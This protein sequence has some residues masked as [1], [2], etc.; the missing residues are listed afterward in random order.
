M[1]FDPAK[2]FAAVAAIA[3]FTADQATK[4]W[5]LEVVMNPPRAIP[6]TPFFNLVLGYNRGVSFGMFNSDGPWN[7]VIFTVIALAIVAWLLHW[8][9]RTR[10]KLTGLSIGLVVGGALGNVLDRLRHPG[11]VDFLDFHAFGWHWPAFNVADAAI[12]VGAVL[13]VA[14]SLFTGRE[15]S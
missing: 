11:V 13:L 5:I 10:R 1:A 7:A 4:W 9:T 8:L 6:V 12:V 14:E 15:T 3:V 2:R